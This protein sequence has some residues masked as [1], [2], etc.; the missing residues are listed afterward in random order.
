MQQWI[1]ISL[2][3]HLDVPYQM[4]VLEERGSVLGH[5]VVVIFVWTKVIFST[6]KP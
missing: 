4:G 2:V 3:P 5:V 6:L 1:L